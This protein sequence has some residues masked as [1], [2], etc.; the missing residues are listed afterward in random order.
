V[1]DMARTFK[2]LGYDIEVADTI[3]LPL[4]EA[5]RWLEPSSEEAKKLYQIMDELKAEGDVTDVYCN[6]IFKKPFIE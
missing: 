3:W 2:T 6:A 5:R 1:L 4:Q